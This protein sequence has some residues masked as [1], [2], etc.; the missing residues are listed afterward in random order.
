MANITTGKVRLSYTHILEPH[1]MNPGDEAKYSTS[2]IISK[3]DTHTLNLLKQ[4]IEGVKSSPQYAAKVGTAANV[5]M[6]L[7]DGDVERADDPAYAGSY[8]LNASS[9]RPVAVFD[10]FKQ[11]TKSAEDIYSGVY[12]YV[13]LNLFCYNTSGNKGISAGLGPIM[14]LGEGEPLGSTVTV[15]EAFG[16]IDAAPKGVDWLQ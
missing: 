9:K 14:V 15:D 11:P 7:R 10:K 16:H 3:S 13:S 8:F 1:A 5:R 2:I 4:A 6:P 12:A